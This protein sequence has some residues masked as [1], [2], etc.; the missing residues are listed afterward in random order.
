M[1]GNVTAVGS[2]VYAVLD[3]VVQQLWGD[4]HEDSL[5]VLLLKKGDQVL[6]DLR[7]LMGF[8][9][10]T[11]GDPNEVLPVYEPQA[12]KLVSSSEVLTTVLT[13]AGANV[14]LINTEILFELCADAKNK[15]A[16]WLIPSPQHIPACSQ[17]RW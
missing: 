11:L 15:P 13:Q 12:R 16:R 5:V 8:G 2:Q 4:S 6:H 10:S 9:K 17:M 7:A 3:A 1:L 14:A